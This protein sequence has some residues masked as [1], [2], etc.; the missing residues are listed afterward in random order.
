MLVSEKAAQGRVHKAKLLKRECCSERKLT[1][2]IGSAATEKPLCGGKQGEVGVGVWGGGRQKSNVT[3][4]KKERKKHPRLPCLPLIN[5]HNK[6]SPV[7]CWFLRPS[8][9]SMFFGANLIS[10]ISRFLSRRVTDS[11]LCLNECWVGR[12]KI[13]VDNAATSLISSS[14]N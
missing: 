3:N 1:P 2:A 10:W 6:V 12:R 13:L 9:L 4:R 5:T 11:C 7:F 8:S 14:N